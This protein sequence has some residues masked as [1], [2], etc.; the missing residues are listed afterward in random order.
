MK[1]YT[2]DVMMSKGLQFNYAHFPKI[3]HG[4]L[5]RGDEKVEGERIAMARA[6]NLAVAWFK[7]FLGA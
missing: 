6:K 1:K 7:E 3:E 5:V 4:G 2:F